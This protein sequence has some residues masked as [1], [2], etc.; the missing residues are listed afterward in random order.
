L[1]VRIQQTYERYLGRAADPAGLAYWLSRYQ[2]GAVNEDIV[3]G[4]IGSDEFFA[5]AT[6]P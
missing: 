5:Q 6:K 4:F 2:D 1:S 3:T